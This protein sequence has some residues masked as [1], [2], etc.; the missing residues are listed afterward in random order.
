MHLVDVYG[1]TDVKKTF[2]AVLILD[3]IV[4]CFCNVF[5]HIGLCIT[6]IILLF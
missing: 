5:L 4:M 6:G 1:D 2:E 3:S